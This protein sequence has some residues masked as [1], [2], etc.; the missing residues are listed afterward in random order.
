VEVSVTEDEAEQLMNE[1]DVRLLVG[2][3]KKELP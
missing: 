3:L 1:T 2:E